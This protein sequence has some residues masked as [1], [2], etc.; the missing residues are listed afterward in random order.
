MEALIISIIEQK[1]RIH[2]L[3]IYFS[4]LIAYLEQARWLVAGKIIELLED[5]PL[6]TNESKALAYLSVLW[7]LE[8]IERIAS[9]T[10]S[11]SLANC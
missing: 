4:I 2:D 10:Y 9:L 11:I 5:N 1:G 8:D 3:T 6:D 7:E